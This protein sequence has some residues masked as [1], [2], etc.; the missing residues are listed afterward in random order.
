MILEHG[1]LFITRVKMYYCQSMCSMN[2]ITNIILYYLKE[3][4]GYKELTDIAK[5][6]IFYRIYNSILS[7]SIH[8]MLCS[9]ILS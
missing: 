2:F 1:K 5:Q 7:V 9:F 8:I 6:I 4:S 3:S